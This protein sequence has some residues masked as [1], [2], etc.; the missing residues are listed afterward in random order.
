MKHRNPNSSPHL[1]KSPPVDVMDAD[2]RFFARRPGRRWYVRRAYPAEKGVA[3]AIGANTSLPP[4]HAAFVLVEQIRPG[5][6]IRLGFGAPAGM[7]TDLSD[8]EIEEALREIHSGT[9]ATSL[10]S[11][12]REA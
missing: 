8:A 11:A 4:D 10:R 12:A 9:M 2:R 7:E 1:R 3:Q 6:R 5:V